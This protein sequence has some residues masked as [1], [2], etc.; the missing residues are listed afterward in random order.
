M[1]S[2]LTITLIRLGYLA[3]LWIMVL[4][5][6]IV[7]KSD[8]YGKVFNNKTP[9]GGQE[10]H[11]KVT[12]KNLVIVEGS[13]VGMSI[14]LIPG[15]TITIGRSPSCTIVI[16]DTYA[17]SLHAKIFNDGNKWIVEDLGS[18]NGTFLGEQKLKAPM[19]MRIG[20]T[21]RIG[22]TIMEMRK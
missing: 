10:Q 17:S 9:K 1:D 8:L 3:L 16:N 18:T 22:Q 7:I 14:Q 15:N 12:N 4:A 6:V 21:I 13:M 19:I 11:D 5:C 2:E 20:D